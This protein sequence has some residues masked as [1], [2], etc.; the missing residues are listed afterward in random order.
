MYAFSRFVFAIALLVTHTAGYGQSTQHPNDDVRIT[1]LST[2]LAD[3]IPGQ[4]YSSIGE[5]GFAAL[6]EVAGRKYLY[7]TGYHPDVVAT[8]VEKLGIDLTDVETVILSHNHGDHI[9]GLLTLREKFRSSHPDALSQVHAGEGF[10]ARRGSDPESLQPSLAAETVARFLATGGNVTMHS[11]PVSLAPGV[12]LTGPVSRVHDE[13]NWSSSGLVVWQDEVVEDFIPEDTS[14]VIETS[15]GLVIVS[16]C[17]HAGII[18]IVDHS[19]ELTGATTVYGAIGGF[20]LFNAGLETI[21]WI[22]D[23]LERADLEYFVGAHCT[24]IEATYAIRKSMDYRRNQSVVGAVG[25]QFTLD[26]IS[27]GLIAR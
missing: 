2:M 8:N 13:R 7:D 17:G 24:G 22:S 14:M 18:N 1:I 21:R 11:K 15:R 9:G 25:Q 10:T 26:G 3:A 5:W 19:L 6:V 27:A 16:G 20:H 12:W 4:S 23:N